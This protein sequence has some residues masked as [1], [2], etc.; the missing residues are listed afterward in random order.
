MG[1][2]F[3]CCG[4]AHNA[5]EPTDM[6]RAPVQEHGHEEEAIDFKSSQPSGAKGVTEDV[7]VASPAQGYASPKHV[8]EDSASPVVRA[9]SSCSLNGISVEE[10]VMQERRSMTMQQMRSRSHTAQSMVSTK[11]FVETIADFFRGRPDFN[12]EWVCIETFGLDD[13]LKELGVSTFKRLAASKA[14]WPSWHFQQDGDR[15]K[16]SNHTMMGVLAEEFV[17]DGS[18]YETVDGHKQ[19]LTCFALWEGDILV[20]E[21]SGPQGHFREER[22]IDENGFLNFTLRGMEQGSKV[23]WGRKFKRKA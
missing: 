13:F 3:A 4:N 21:R 12:G 19:T 10:D 18:T 6:T 17:A 5:E 8:E 2:H 20:I 16:F 9:I 14:P 7:R 22:R 1:N 15:I 11:S 23:V